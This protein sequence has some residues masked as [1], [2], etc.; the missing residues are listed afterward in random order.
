MGAATPDPA[1][2]PEVSR[3]LEGQLIG[4][5]FRLGRLLGRGGMGEVREAEHVELGRRVAV[6]IMHGRAAQNR[7]SVTRLKREARSLASISHPNIVEVLDA[8]EH[9]G[10]PYL[11]MELLEGEDLRTRIDRVGQIPVGEA[12]AIASQVLAGLDAVHAGG[13]IHRDVK[14]ENVF[15]TPQPDGSL[16]VKL[17][18]FG[19]S[20]LME[21]D[22]S[23]GNLTESGTIVG[24]PAFMAPEQAIGSAGID[25][26]TD[27]YSV[28]AVLYTMLGGRPPFIAPNIPAVLLAIV[29]G[30]AEP[31]ASLRP[32][33]PPGLVQVVERAME[34][35]RGKR[36]RS[37]GE[38]AEALVP[39]APT[40]TIAVAARSRRLRRVAPRV[41]LGGAVLAA[42]VIFVSG[43]RAPAPRAA[44]SRRPHEAA[45]VDETLAPPR[46]PALARRTSASPA[47]ARLR[48]EVR[49][50]RAAAAATVEID[51]ETATGGLTS[52]EVS[53]RAHHVEVRA[54]GYVPRE[55]SVVVERDVVVPIV[56]EPEGA[57]PRGEPD[58]YRGPLKLVKERPF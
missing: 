10:S 57:R 21:I 43:R 50:A 29:E 5:R 47:R 38:F 4:G 15:L 51:G 35:E 45:V 25:A 23:A 46:P 19:V 24:S 31:L 39:F 42:M 53:K 32:A 56:L 33:L 52:L 3:G 28:G 55:L 2:E 36:F 12:I 54:A 9:D 27:L 26:R 22:S 44:P 30:K 13:I 1:Q 58:T 6:K 20:K 7:S 16:F 14:P 48:V 34:K 37:A 40:A 11:V 17:L 8:G 49:P 18:D 41:L